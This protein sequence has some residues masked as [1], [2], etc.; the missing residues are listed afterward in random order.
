MNQKIVGVVMST[1]K[2]LYTT[3][4]HRSSIVQHINITTSKFLP[5]CSQGRGGDLA[6]D[7]GQEEAALWVQRCDQ[8]WPERGSATTGGQAEYSSLNINVYI[9]FL[10]SKSTISNLLSTSSIKLRQEKGY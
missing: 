10:R 9:I 1:I 8:G 6:N 4:N 2:L 7:P 3:N 5:S